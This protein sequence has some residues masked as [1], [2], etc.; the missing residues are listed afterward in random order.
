[1]ASSFQIQIGVCQPRPGFAILRILGDEILEQV[2][3]NSPASALY[4][5]RDRKTGLRIGE[6]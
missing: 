2:N 5:L 3:G 1:M 4:F 6:E